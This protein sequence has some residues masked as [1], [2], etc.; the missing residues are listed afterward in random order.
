MRRNAHRSLNQAC[1]PLTPFDPI[2]MAER[3]LA[4]RQNLGRFDRSIYAALLRAFGLVVVL[5]R[6]AANSLATAFWSFSVS[7]R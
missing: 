7:T 3:K 4:L 2:K 5:S 6:F 1:G